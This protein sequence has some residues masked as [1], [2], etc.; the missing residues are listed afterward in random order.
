MPVFSEIYSM[1]NESNDVCCSSRQDIG[2]IKAFSKEMTT[3][4][5]TKD[6]KSKTI[7]DGITNFHK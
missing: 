3:I 1:Y 4:K 6:E 5:I 7:I 2:T